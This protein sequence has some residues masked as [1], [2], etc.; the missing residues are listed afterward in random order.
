MKVEIQKSKS[1]TFEW[2]FYDKNIKE[3]PVSGTIKITKPGG[4]TALVDTTVV[5]V[6]TDG[7]ILYTLAS[8]NTGTLGKNYK[9]ELTYQVG[10]VVKRPFYLFDIVET[11]LV[12]T[13]RDE[14]LFQYVEELRA[15]GQTYVKETSSAGTTSTLISNELNFLNVDFKGGNVEI[16]IDDTTNHDAEITAWD[17]NT[18][19]IT[20]SPA[21]SVSIGTGLKFTIRASF[22]RF[23]N[24]A[25]ETIVYRDIRNRVPIAAGYIDSTVTNNMTIFKALEIICFSKAEEPDDKWD[26]R[27]KQFKQMYKDEYVK[28]NEA[29]DYNEDGDIDNYEQNDKPSFMNKGISR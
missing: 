26:M 10:D 19:T 28:L 23:I 11:P 2:S 1:H 15:Q 6:E 21:Y 25:Y 16:F 8:A 20:F 9:I 5:S 22:Q 7:T 13:V 4:S 3:V 29:Y 17:K 18:S 27:A 24:R 14:D 12:N